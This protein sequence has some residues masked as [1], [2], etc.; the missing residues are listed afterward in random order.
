MMASCSRLLPYIPGHAHEVFSQDA[1]NVRLAIPPVQQGLGQAG[2]LLGRHVSGAAVGILVFRPI[3]PASGEGLVRFVNMQHAVHAEPDMI[4]PD[5]L[6]HVVDVYHQ[7]LDSRAAGPEKTADAGDAN[8]A[9]SRSTGFD[10]VIPYVALMVPQLTR[11]GVAEDDRCLGGL[12]CFHGGSVG[13][14]GT[15][16]DHTH[17]VHL[18]HHAAPKVG[19]ADVLVMAAATGEIVAVVGEQHLANAEAVVKVDHADVA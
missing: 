1:A 12:D 13:A 16:D 4:G 8:H 18:G 3:M 15:I 2:S 7:M 9:P 10:L 19:E 17:A 6:D 11:I 14:V 5:E